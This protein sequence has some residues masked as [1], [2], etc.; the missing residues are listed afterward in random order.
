VDHVRT[1]LPYALVAGIVGIVV[2]DIA[3]ALGLPVVVALP[4][5]IA[6]VVLIVRL[7]GRRPEP[8]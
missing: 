6:I 5:G 7:R 3:T 1:Q 8:T 2:G 4:L